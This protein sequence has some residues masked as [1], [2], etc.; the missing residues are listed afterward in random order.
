MNLP[1]NVHWDSAESMRTILGL[2]FPDGNILDVNYSLGVFY[3]KVD[4]RVVGI[5]I[6]PLADAVADNRALPFADD[7]FD[8][9]V[10]D[11]PYRR[12]NGDTKYTKRYGVAPYTAKRVSQQY[13]D[14]LPEL[15]RV[16]RTGIIIKAQDETDGHRFYHRMFALVGFIKNLTGLEPHDVVYL[17]KRGVMDNN[18]EGRQ[19]HFSA[20]CV[21]YFIV[22]KWACKS[23][24][25]PIRFAGA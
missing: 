15:L 10:C 9:G 12:G 13:Y 3:N 25:R 16:S 5:D 7:S 22:Y 4:R 17:V 14:L 1:L 21:S 20:N 8:V 2:H 19:R 24:F 11:P 23:P 18:V 6:R